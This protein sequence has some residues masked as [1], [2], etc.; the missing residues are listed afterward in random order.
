M[1]IILGDIEARYDGIAFIG[2]P[3]S[4]MTAGAR[5]TRI[6]MWHNYSRLLVYVNTK[7]LQ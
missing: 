5:N 4:S 1:Q 7:M 6:V 2:I 3:S